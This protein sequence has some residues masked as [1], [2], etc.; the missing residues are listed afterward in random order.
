MGPIE[1]KAKFWTVQLKSVVQTVGI[2]G[3]ILGM[4]MYGGYGIMMRVIDVVE[5]KLE[6]VTSATV[7]H[8]AEQT[9]TT[10]Q[11][12]QTMK[13]QSELI[14]GLHTKVDGVSSRI[15]RIEIKLD[16]RGQPK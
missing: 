1:D 12:S 7:D 16:S 2:S 6:R 8:M 3:V 11:I 4:V 14:Q 15:E 5:P 9:A 13:Q 10:K